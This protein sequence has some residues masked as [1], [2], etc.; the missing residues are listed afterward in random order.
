MIAQPNRRGT[1]LLSS[2][3]YSTQAFYESSPHN[4]LAQPAGHL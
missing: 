4:H 2:L 1:L 3:A